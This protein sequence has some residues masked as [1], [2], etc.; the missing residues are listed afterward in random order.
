MN[1]KHLIIPSGGSAGFITYGA[2][3]QLA[4]KG[5]WNI[6]KIKSIY[7]SSIGA[8]I[9][10]VILLDYKWEWLD[11]FFY[12]RPWSD[13]VK[14]NPENIINFY[15]KKGLL[16]NDIFYK[17]MEP[18]LKGKGMTQNITMR[19]FYEKTNIDFHIYTTNL[20][21]NELESV[22]INH[23]TYPD[24]ELCNAITMS[25]SIPG[26][27]SPVFLDDKCLIDGGC[28]NNIPI[29]DCMKEK[30]INIDE[31]LVFTNIWKERKYITEETNIGDIYLKLIWS[32]VKK[33]NILLNDKFI[34]KVKHNVYL[35]ATNA[36]SFSSW[37][38][39]L[40]NKEMRASLIEEG[41]VNAKMFCNYNKL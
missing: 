22:I 37:S 16:D 26:I 30:D 33:A 3:R 41:I 28:L 9:G 36:T 12:K 23:K 11:D 5:V 17:I 21:N 34:K 1:I 40:E 29:G 19:E 31:I 39:I 32:L 4:K 13:V 38:E 25:S 10:A 35:N 14:I 18:L 27:M 15:K 7:G 20:N 2:L 8:F 6:K 24:V